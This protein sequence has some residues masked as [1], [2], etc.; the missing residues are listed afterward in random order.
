MLLREGESGPTRL[1]WTHSCRFTAQPYIRAP[2]HPQLGRQK[3]VRR[4]TPTER[5]ADVLAQS[6]AAD[7][8]RALGAALVGIVSFWRRVAAAPD[9]K[10]AKAAIARAAKPAR[11]WT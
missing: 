2:A 5:V 11:A 8:P 3:A 7:A 1:R 9:S 6:D 10:A 4:V